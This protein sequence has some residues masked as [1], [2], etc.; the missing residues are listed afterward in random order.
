[1]SDVTLSEGVVVWHNHDCYKLLIVF[2]MNLLASWRS[3]LI[4]VAD[5]VKLLILLYNF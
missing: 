2:W 1:M 3:I 5:F 4:K